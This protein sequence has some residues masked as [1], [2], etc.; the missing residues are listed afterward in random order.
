MD[1]WTKR[2]GPGRRGGRP[3]PVVKK[4][5]GL[6]EGGLDVDRRAGGGEGE[7]VA[8]DFLAVH[9]QGLDAFAQAVGVVHGDVVGG[10]AVLAGDLEAGPGLGHA[11]VEAEAVEAGLDAED[12]LRDGDEGPGGGAGEPGVLGLARGGGVAA[13]DHLR[14]DVGLAPIRLV[15]DLLDG[16]TDASVI[17][18]DA[19]AFVL[20]A[21]VEVD[22][23]VVVAEDAGVFFVAGRVAGDFAELDVVGRVGW[24]LLDDA[25]VVVEVLVLAFD[26]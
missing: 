12:A 13:G 4:R 21:Q 19:V 20:L 9:E 1:L 18:V 11:R 22:P 16:V 10:A 14:I 25:V 23:G 17:L 6:A 3:G 5:G 26:G 2:E 7:N 24:L 8:G 15:L